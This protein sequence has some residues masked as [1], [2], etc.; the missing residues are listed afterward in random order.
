[1]SIKAHQWASQ[2]KGLTRLEK[3]VLKEIANRYSDEKGKAWPS[4]N[5]IARDTGYSRASVCRG[6][7]TLEEKGLVVRINAFDSETGARTSNRYFLPTFDPTR[8]PR[9]KAPIKVESYWDPHGSFVSEESQVTF[10]TVPS[11]KSIEATTATM[12]QNDNDL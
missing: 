10:E 1:M 9:S 5:R 3:T 12:F 8:V 6:L 11:Q 2:H 4:Q 7:K